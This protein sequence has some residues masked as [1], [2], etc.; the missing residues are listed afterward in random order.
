MLML[1]KTICSIDW[2]C[3]ADVI[4]RVLAL[5]EDE[6]ELIQKRDADI[7]DLYID[8]LVSD[9]ENGLLEDDRNAAE[10]D[11]LLDACRKDK[12]SALAADLAKEWESDD[13][14]EMDRDDHGQSNAKRIFVWNCDGDHTAVHYAILPVAVSQ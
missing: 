2:K 10:I 12:A 9:L 11:Q 8:D 1:L 13:R 5:S 14:W 4:N 6:N 3:R 7:V